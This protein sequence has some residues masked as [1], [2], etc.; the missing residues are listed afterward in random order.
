MKEKK[1]SNS[2]DQEINEALCVAL[3]AMKCKGYNPLTQLTMYALSEDG[4]YITTY[5]GAREK[6]LK[7]SNE[8]I[9]NHLLRYYFES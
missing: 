6:M 2:K 5:N 9:V 7:F 4:C 1:F 3:D 8:D